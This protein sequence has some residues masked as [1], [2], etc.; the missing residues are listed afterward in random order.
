MKRLCNSEIE[1]SMYWWEG[2]RVGYGIIKSYKDNRNASNILIKLLDKDF[3]K[4]IKLMLNRM[5]EIAKVVETND[6][7]DYNKDV[8]S[9]LVRNMNSQLKEKKK[10]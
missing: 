1:N 3:S 5:L 7:V 9:K 2:Y 4:E 10:V 8:I 6:N